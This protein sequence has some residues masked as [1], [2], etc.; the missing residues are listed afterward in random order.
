M[1]AND[2]EIF[3][4]PSTV[5]PGIPGVVLFGVTQKRQQQTGAGRLDSDGVVSQRVSNSLP[6]PCPECGFPPPGALVGLGGAV[7][8]TIS[9]LHD[10]PAPASWAPPPD[11]LPM[12]PAAEWGLAGAIFRRSLHDCGQAVHGRPAEG[13]GAT[14]RSSLSRL[15]GERARAPCSPGRLRHHQPG[16]SWPLP[17]LSLP[18]LS[19]PPHRSLPLP[20]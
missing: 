15:L 1:N 10:F 6:P 11:R 12:T 20:S 5:Q 8:S 14:G 18:L 7:R 2:R 9:R 13:R 16:E 17:L 19:S 4:Y 3:Y